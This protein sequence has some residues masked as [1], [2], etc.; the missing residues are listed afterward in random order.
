MFTDP[1]RSDGSMKRPAGPARLALKLK[2]NSLAL[3]LGQVDIRADTKTD[4]C[5]VNVRRSGEPRPE[6][7]LAGRSWRY[8]LD[9]GSYVLNVDLVGMAGD[10]VGF[11]FS[12]ASPNDPTKLTLP[13]IPGTASSDNRDISF[14]VP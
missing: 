2:V 11:A 8:L 10:L 4:T 9:N 14:T 3:S 7:R 13:G 1:R 6:A 5:T 12:G